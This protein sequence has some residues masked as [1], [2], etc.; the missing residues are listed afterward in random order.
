L[1]T[2]TSMTKM[3]AETACPTRKH[4]VG[5]VRSDTLGARR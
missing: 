5:H 3:F 4:L 1:F 2:T